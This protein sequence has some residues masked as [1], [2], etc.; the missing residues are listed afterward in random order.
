MTTLRDLRAIKESKGLPAKAFKKFKFNNSH[1]TKTI[2]KQF[3][4]SRVSSGL[5]ARKT[6]LEHNIFSQG[7]VFTEW[8]WSVIYPLSTSIMVL[9][10][11][12]LSGEKMKQEKE[13]DQE[14]QTNKE[15]MAGSG[16]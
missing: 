5:S 10:R 16:K 6:K 14:E 7:N 3:H 8:A 15:K 1:Q 9:Q 11:L 12:S 2:G 13:D 4:V